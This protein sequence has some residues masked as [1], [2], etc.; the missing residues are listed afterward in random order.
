ML[1]HPSFFAPFS[2][3]FF[4]GSICFFRRRECYFSYLFRTTHRVKTQQVVKSRGQHCGDIELPG[5][6]ANAA[7]PVPLILDLRLAHDRFGCSSDPTLNGRLHYNDIDKSLNEDVNDKIRKYRADYNNNPTDA[8][9]CMSDIV[10]TNGRLHSDFIR[11]LFLQ[12]HRETDRFYTVSGLQSAQ[13]NLGATCF[14]FRRAAVLNQPKSKCGLLR[15][16]LG[17]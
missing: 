13:S 10:G 1:L 11:L 8:V 9:V 7:G 16:H 15:K 3:L 14:H 2:E 12:S 6:L 4:F 17:Y 5:Y